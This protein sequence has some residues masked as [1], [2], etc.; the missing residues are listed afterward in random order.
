MAELQSDEGQQYPGPARGR[1]G[2][3]LFIR[4]LLATG[5]VST[6]QQAEYVLL[7]SA[8]VMLV[9]AFFLF[10]L[11]GG[12]TARVPQSVID[13]AMNASAN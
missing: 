6:D 3:S 2:K 12:S 7:S 1:T 9:L 5:I 11:S 13:A 8:M 10:S 4:L